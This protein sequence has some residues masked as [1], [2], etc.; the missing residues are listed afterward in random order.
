[1][2]ELQREFTK[3]STVS[4][5]ISILGV[6]GSVP[7]TFNIPISSGGP[8]TAVWCWLFGS[9]MAMLISA[10]VS[11]LVSAYPTAGGMYFVCKHV[12]PSRHVPIW[13]WI[14]G[15][16]NFVGQAAGV[17]ALAYTVS[18]MLLA[19]ISMNS[20]LE[21]DRYQFSPTAGQTVVLALALLVLMGAICSLTTKSLHRIV[22]WFAPINVVASIGICITLLVLTPNKHHPL[23]VFTH[24]TDGSGWGSK[25]F[26]FL[27]GFLSVAWTMTDYDGTTHMSEETHDAAILGPLAI[28]TA[29]LSSGLLGWLLTITF[30]ICL[31]D[32][33]STI[34]TPTG[35]PVA[36]I[37]LNAAGQKWGTFMWFFVILVQFFTGISAMLACTRMAYAFARDGGFPMSELWSE[38][39][40][41]TQ[42]PLNA[43]WLVVAFCSLLDCIALGRQQTIVAI[44]S[45]TA[46]AL[47]LSY[48]A[49]IIARLYYA[50]EVDFIPGPFTLGSWGKTINIISAIWVLF[51]SVILFF[52]P[53]WPITG[54]NMNYAI[55]VAIGMAFFA[56]SWWWAGAGGTYSGPRTTE[57][58]EPVA[59][60]EEDPEEVEAEREQVVGAVKPH[61]SRPRIYESD[62]GSEVSTD[63]ED[64]LDTERV[65]WD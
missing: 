14:V 6:L 17:S 21:G 41:Y 2:S 56:L 49:V 60:D 1:M 36:Q 39:N 12:V 42:T 27:L 35:M 8:A 16:C 47:D 45:L 20:R 63:S 46:P 52:P 10:S 18:Q 58:F 29:V 7:A 3:W 50:S 51:I 34:N 31:G 59:G 61:S 23:W 19:A 57:G 24:F 22:C 33:E 30:C 48:I 40:E 64:V 5:A 32:L 9:C 65:R 53:K 62:E 15:W 44:F 25:T 54:E 37:F 4:Y 55:F 38:V 43:V 13:S 11:E 26:S 28:N